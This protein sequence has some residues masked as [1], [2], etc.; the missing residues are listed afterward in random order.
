MEIS[1]KIKM[2]TLKPRTE[3]KKS[4]AVARARTERIVLRNGKTRDIVCYYIEDG[5]RDAASEARTRTERI[6]LRNGKTRDIA[7]KT[8]AE[9]PHRRRRC[10]R[11]PWDRMKRIR[12]RRCAQS[13]WDRMKR[14]ENGPE[15]Q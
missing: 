4:N 13:P 5:G 8:G 6:V 7:L 14:I 2:K 1:K 3:K 15:K 11:S 10:A 9:M 12:R